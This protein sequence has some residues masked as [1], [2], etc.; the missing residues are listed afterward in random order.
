MTI[1]QLQ[2]FVEVTRG[3]SFR[4]AAD[5]LHLSQPSVSAN[6]HSLETELGFPLFE[7]SGRRV[8]LT[9]AGE[10][11]LLYAEHVL[12]ALDDARAAVDS[13]YAVPK[14]TLRIGTT[15]SLVGTLVPPV[16][17]QFATSGAGCDRAPLGNQ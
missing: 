2:C 13:L 17:R 14:G 10:M 11:L 6:V 5:R 9:R 3:L 7:R 4:R 15:S 12:V 16:I 1:N 8:R